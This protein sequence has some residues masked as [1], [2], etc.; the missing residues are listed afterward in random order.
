MTPTAWDFRNK[1][2][3]ILNTAKHSGKSYVDVESGNL[4]KELGVDANSHHRLPIFHEVMTKMMRPGDLI[5]QE[6]S[7]GERATMRI[8]YVLKAKHENEKPLHS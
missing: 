3:V 8:R 6:T 7:D 4:H 1:L 2:T 5:L